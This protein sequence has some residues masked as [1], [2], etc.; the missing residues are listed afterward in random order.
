M[1]LTYF[2]IERTCQKVQEQVH[3]ILK[4]YRLNAGSESRKVTTQKVRLKVLRQLNKCCRCLIAQTEQDASASCKLLYN[5]GAIT[6]GVGQHKKQVKNFN[7]PLSVE[8]PMEN[9]KGTR[10]QLAPARL[11]SA[12]RILEN[13]ANGGTKSGEQVL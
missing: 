4:R 12:P 11:C 2:K 5:H 7:M 13:F 6:L 8:H 1:R 3:S 9:S 10:N